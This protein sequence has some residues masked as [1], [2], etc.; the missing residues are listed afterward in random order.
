MSCVGGGGGNPMPDN[1]V[2]GQTCG[3]C[4][5]FVPYNEL[6]VKD[7]GKLCD[8]LWGYC[9]HCKTHA[10]AI[11]VKPTRMKKVAKMR[12]RERLFP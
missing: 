9:P 11:G 2:D 12:V 5:R 3:K 1:A 4:N 7:Y 10:L 8:H 6:V